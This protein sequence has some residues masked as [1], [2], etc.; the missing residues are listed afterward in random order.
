MGRYLD[1]YWNETES[2]IRDS[3]NPRESHFCT[4]GYINL[5]EDT[6]LVGHQIQQ[7]SIENVQLNLIHDRQMICDEEH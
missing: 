3:I 5:S 7:N 2:N 6:D 1:K 4:A